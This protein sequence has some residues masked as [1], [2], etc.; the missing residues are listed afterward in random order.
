MPTDF[1]IARAIALARVVCG[2]TVPVPPRCP[3]A[4]L[5]TK[6]RV[7]GAFAPGVVGAP[8]F[9]DATPRGRH[10]AQR[11]KKLPAGTPKGRMT[12]I[13]SSAVAPNAGTAWAIPRQ[14]GC[15]KPHSHCNPLLIGLYWV[16]TDASLS[17]GSRSDRMTLSTQ[18]GMTRPIKVAEGLFAWY[19][20][21]VTPYAA[22][23]FGV[24]VAP[25]LR[26]RREGTLRL[27]D[28][29]PAAG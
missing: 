10:G 14:R 4:S 27:G 21:L 2:S 1:D 11:Y 29:W 12:R 20:V 8:C 19:I 26:V 15:E 22:Q 28:G 24:L 16:A 9:W 6:R 7:G 23:V 3:I 25:D 18:L 5:F 17:A 13:G